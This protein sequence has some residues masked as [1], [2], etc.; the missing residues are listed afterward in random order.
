MAT[1]SVRLPTF[2]G[3]YSNGMMLGQIYDKSSWQYFTNLK[4]FIPEI[5]TLSKNR[6]LFMALQNHLEFKIALTY[7][8]L[9]IT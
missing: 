9:V 4:I 8:S 6:C 1:M 3:F 7:P 5:I 2:A